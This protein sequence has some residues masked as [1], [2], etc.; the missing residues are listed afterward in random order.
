MK[1]IRAG[2]QEIG[3]SKLS[4][5][6]PCDWSQ[7]RK[8]DRHRNDAE[9]PESGQGDRAGGQRGRGCAEVGVEGKDGKE[10]H[11]LQ[12]V[13]R[14]NCDTPTACEEEAIGQSDDNK[15]MCFTRQV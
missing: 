11:S 2:L 8:T 3:P 15:I 5:L 12:F 1:G 13:R 4:V 14:G 9:A 7:D 10:A 6:G